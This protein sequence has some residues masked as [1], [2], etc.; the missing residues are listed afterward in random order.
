M[1]L[2]ACTSSCCVPNVDLIDLLSGEVDLNHAGRQVA[3]GHRFLCCRFKRRNRWG[4]DKIANGLRLSDDSVR[5]GL[6]LAELARLLVVERE[7]GCKLAV[8]VL[9]LPDPEAGPKRPTLYGR[10][11]GAGGSRPLGSRG[12]LSR[13]GP[14]VGSW[15][16]GIDRPSS[17]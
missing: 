2:V 13:S 15:R 17:S 6:H 10:S 7:A 11:L 9:D 4:P 3:M 12:G 5:R 8:S 16:A 14:P 1:N